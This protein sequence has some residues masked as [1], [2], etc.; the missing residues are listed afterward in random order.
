MCSDYDPRPR[1]GLGQAISTDGARASVSDVGWQKLAD[2]LPPT[3]YFIMIMEPMGH[4]LV[5][6]YVRS[7]AQMVHPGS[8]VII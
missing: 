1:R 4:V 6:G 5:Q 2:Q 3:V 8:Q 7:T